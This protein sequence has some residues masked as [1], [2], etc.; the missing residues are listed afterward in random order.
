[1]S[2]VPEGARSSGL[3]RPGQAR[4]RVSI[5]EVLARAGIE[6][7]GSG[8]ERR[9]RCQRPGHTD[10]NPSCY[11]NVVK[12]EWYCPVCG[13][14]GGANDLAYLLG[15][16]AEERAE[17]PRSVGPEPQDAPPKPA[18]ADIWA[19]LPRADAAAEKGLAARYVG[20]AL[21]E[22]LVRAHV[23]RT[24]TRLDACRNHRIAAPVRNSKGKLIAVEFR[25]VIQDVP[26]KEKWRA[27]GHVKGGWY[28]DP[29]SINASTKTVVIVEGLFDWIVMSVFCG[30]DALVLGMQTADKHPD[31]S[32]LDG[33]KGRVFL[34]PHNDEP[35][36]QAMR[37]A[38]D[39]LA[40]ME[41]ASTVAVPV[42]SKPKGDLADVW[43]EF[44]GD[45]SQF[46]ARLREAIS[47]AERRTVDPFEGAA[48]VVAPE[49]P[50]AEKTAPTTADEDD[51]ATPR[52]RGDRQRRRKYRPEPPVPESLDGVGKPFK[53]MRKYYF[54]RL[55][56]RLAASQSRE[57]TE[58]DTR[59]HPKVLNPREK[60]VLARL[61]SGEDKGWDQRLQSIA[62]EFGTNRSSIHQA[63]ESLIAKG[64]VAPRKSRF[65]RYKIRRADA[66]LR[67]TKRNFNVYVPRFVL[68]RITDA[69]ALTFAVILKKA[70]DTSWAAFTYSDLGV[71]TG[72]SEDYLRKEVIP[73]LVEKRLI[74]KPKRRG[75]F[76]TLL[77]PW[78]LAEGRRTD[79]PADEDPADDEEES[80]EDES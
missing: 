7:E 78:H 49:Q 59:S 21:R 12:G 2:S 6:P 25:H 51:D 31:V 40:E 70:G 63:I 48:N 17:F 14:G 52:Q 54:V 73:E 67:N 4:A 10:R 44:R 29:A 35:G 50:S 38:A 19:A 58:G 32:F 56:A 9:I 53:Y 80:E 27:C 5:L 1:M 46:R 20:S 28:G 45:S 16:R 13:V 60:L 34:F 65:S 72:L 47:E 74:E 30:Q 33:F 57:G 69:A 55:P 62:Q 68:G 11:V 41:V 22:G 26:R 61:V 24:G 18:P 42:T 76:T 15:I 8:K 77:H 23:G 71:A 39:A 75:T 3:Y 43:A 64:L 79:A 66:A 36:I 37:G